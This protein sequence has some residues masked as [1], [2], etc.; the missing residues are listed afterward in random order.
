MVMSRKLK[1]NVP[2]MSQELYLDDTQINNIHLKDGNRLDIR[3]KNV[4][5]YLTGLYL[6]YSPKTQS[7]VFYL[8]YFYEGKSQ[9]LKL[10]PF[11]PNSYGSI[12]VSKE[13]I[14]QGFVLAC[15][16]SPKTDLKILINLI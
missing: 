16:S 3:F 7:K 1:L 12:Q 2:G 6:R 13:V 11:L 5:D 9:W 14:K 8:K 10:K 15:K 4:P